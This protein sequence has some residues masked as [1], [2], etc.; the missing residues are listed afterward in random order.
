[1]IHT[2]KTIIGIAG[3]SGLGIRLGSES[4]NSLGASSHT[5]SE[6]AHQHDE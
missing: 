2:S 6:E 5:G 3:I 1:M 4:S